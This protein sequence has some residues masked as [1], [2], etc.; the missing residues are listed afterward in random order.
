M[1]D[2]C[3]FERDQVP[4]LIFACPSICRTPCSRNVTRKVL[5]HS[6]I[7]LKVGCGLQVL[8]LRAVD[9]LLLDLL[10]F[11]LDRS[12]LLFA[13]LLIL[14]FE[15]ARLDLAAE[16]RALVDS[17]EVQFLVNRVSI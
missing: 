2:C 17:R 7:C 3:L 13:V 16:G 10:I 15:A 6:P 8:C 12:Q 1:V 5:L 4:V 11:L 14:S 9:V